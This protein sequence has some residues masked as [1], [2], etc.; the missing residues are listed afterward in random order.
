MT[1]ALVIDDNREAADTIGSMLSY[2]NVEPQI[3]YGPRAAM[4]ILQDTK[5]DIVFMDINMPGVDGFEVLGYLR[6]FPQMQNTP[7]VF[8]TADSQPE[9]AGRVRKTGA[10]LIIIKPITME[11]LETALRKAGLLK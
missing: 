1:T 10:L 9:T 6:R 7:V 5:P 3:A 4:L 8:V 2:L 11:G